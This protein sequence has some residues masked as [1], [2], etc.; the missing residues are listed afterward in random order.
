M[1]AAYL[2]AAAGNATHLGDLVGDELVETLRRPK[3]RKT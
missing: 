2:T 1:I 3:R